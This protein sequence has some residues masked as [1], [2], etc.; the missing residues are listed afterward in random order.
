MSIIFGKRIQSATGEK[1]KEQLS[2][3]EKGCPQ[4]GFSIWLDHLT[5]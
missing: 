3:S 5:G 1:L 4:E 2:A